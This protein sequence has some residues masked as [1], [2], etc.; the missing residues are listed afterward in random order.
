MATPKRK[1]WATSF[2]G[3]P[4]DFRIRHGSNPVAYQ[5][6]RRYAEL[7][8]AGQLRSPYVTVWVDHRDGKGWTV[9][10]RIDLREQQP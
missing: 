7:Y 9:H 10:E 6:I 2:P 5:R 3:V 1:L 4:G 8:A